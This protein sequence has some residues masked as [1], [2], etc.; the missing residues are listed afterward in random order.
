MNDYFLLIILLIV[1]TMGG[2][3]G[4]L[5]GVQLGKREAFSSIEFC[6]CGLHYER[7]PAPVR[8]AKDRKFA[9]DVLSAEVIE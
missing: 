4:G 3:I 5:I 9:R 2:C 7:E 6:D 8:A 1:F